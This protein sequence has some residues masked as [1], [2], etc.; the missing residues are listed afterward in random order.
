MI[1]KS[2]EKDIQNPI[3]QS[4][5]RVIVAYFLTVMA[6]FVAAMFP[7][8]RIWGF[9]Q[10]AYFSLEWRIV[11]LAIAVLLPVLWSAL[12]K[13]S[14][15]F[16]F[17]I[18]ESFLGRKHNYFILALLVTIVMAAA[19]YFLRS[20]THFLGDGYM[21]LSSL[22]SNKPLV[23][24]TAFGAI[25]AHIWLKS[26]IGGDDEA[27]SL[28]TFQIISILGGVIF[29]ILVFYLAHKLF[30]SRV[31]SALFALGLSSGG[32]MHLFFGYVEYYALFVLSVTLFTLIGLL[33]SKGHLSKWLILPPLIIAIFFHVLGVTLIPSALFLLISGTKA[34]KF[35]GTI[36]HKSKWLLAAVCGALCLAVYYYCYTTSYRFRF[37][38]VPVFA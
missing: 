10:W 16:I 17:N 33:I 32:Y 4:N 34:G 23:K 15:T 20:K 9:N 31:D 12:T 11:F 18:F 26:L 5:N 27:A 6:I 25:K 30:E 38:V 13:N 37:A 8:N 36:S 14:N 24:E 28:L 29:L 35:I 19:F 2:K 3:L 22:A 21:N 7:E 1:S